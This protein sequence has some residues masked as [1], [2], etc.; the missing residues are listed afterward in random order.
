MTILT[1]IVV[2]QCMSIQLNFKQCNYTEY[3]QP[4]FAIIFKDQI[5]KRLRSKS[6]Q[7]VLSFRC[8]ITCSRPKSDHI[9]RIL[10][11]M[12]FKKV[13]YD[14]LLSYGLICG[15][16]LSSA[17]CCK[18][19]KTTH[20]FCRISPTFSLKAHTYGHSVPLKNIF[21]SCQNL[22]FYCFWSYLA[23]LSTLL[24]AT[25]PSSTICTFYT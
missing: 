4:P 6:L 19:I 23:Y 16:P 9:K 2:K 24:G 11:S 13:K 21:I 3:Y 15:C 7:F 18:N 5:Y 8:F 1:T 25:Y 12:V 20:K 22:K 14:Q 17:W 10:R